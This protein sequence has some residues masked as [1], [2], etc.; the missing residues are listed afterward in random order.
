MIGPVP[1][2]RQP[3]ATPA[4]WP[5]VVHHVLACPHCQGRLTL[6]EEGAACAVPACAAVFGRSASGLLDLRLRAPK[7]VTRRIS[8]GAEGPPP[9][10][11][12][13]TLADN[14]RPEV[15]WQGIDRPASLR[16]RMQSWLPLA[17]GAN[18]LA[19]DVGCGSAAFRPVL[20]RCGFGYVGIDVAGDDATLIADARALPFRDESFELV[21][22]NAV[23]QYVSHPEVALAEIYRVLQPGGAFMGTIGFLEAF[24]GHNMHPATP[25]GADRYFRDAGFVVE[26]LAPDDTWTG[27]IAL[28][29]TMFPGLPGRSADFLV[30]PLDW[31]SRV[32]WQLG[33]LFRD[34]IGPGDRLLKL[35]GGV[36]FVLRKS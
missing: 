17:R 27:P 26:Q 6:H 13:R 18:A 19:L 11:A 16:A 34:G 30:A 20:A 14:P 33:T 1:A 23:L 22:S 29:R 28:A 8:F 2:T 7:T 31:C 36:E 10:L 15:D 24:D 12:R 35:T 3:E 9:E 5:Q 32:Y 21:W 25:L 4:W